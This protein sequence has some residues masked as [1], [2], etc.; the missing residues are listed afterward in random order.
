MKQMC[1]LALASDRLTSVGWY[2]GLFR[3]H[4]VYTIYSSHWELLKDVVIGDTSVSLHNKKRGN[5]Y[6]A[7]ITYW[8]C[9]WGL[10]FELSS[11]S[12]PGVLRAKLSAG[13]ILQLDLF[14]VKK[15]VVSEFTL[16]KHFMQ[17]SRMCLIWSTES[18][19]HHN[20]Q[21]MRLRPKTY[22]KDKRMP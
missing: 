4:C 12:S 13:L 6:W 19:R 11:I 2:P 16:E 7:F 22:G 15:R 8:N 14:Q 3:W 1:C 10:Y 21:D 9:I 5:L 20:I 18:T 17:L